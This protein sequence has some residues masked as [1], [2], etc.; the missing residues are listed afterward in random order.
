MLEKGKERDG[1]RREKGVRR[2]SKGMS[3]NEKM[4]EK[5]I[6]KI[7]SNECRFQIAQR[8]LFSNIPTADD[9]R[10]V[11]ILHGHYPAQHQNVGNGGVKT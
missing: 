3:E 1:K 9:Y 5:R 7:N 4:E 8:L 11:D 6:A 10:K 2:E